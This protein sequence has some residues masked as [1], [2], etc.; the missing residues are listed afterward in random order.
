ME[1]RA[2]TIRN[3]DMARFKK[4]LDAY[5][6]TEAQLVFLD[7]V[8]LVNRNMRRSRG[9][10]PEGQSLV[11]QVEF[12]RSDKASL[13]CFIR[14][15]GLLESLKTLLLFF[16]CTFVIGINVSVVVYYGLPFFLA[17]FA[18]SSQFFI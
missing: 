3:S 11:V 5:K 1:R 17:C 2:I 15:D 10:A 13:L 14:A 6:Y 7:E 18:F 4:E 9:Y 8:S 16:Y 12:S